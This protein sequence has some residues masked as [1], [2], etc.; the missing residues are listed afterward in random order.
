MERS[1]GADQRSKRALQ[2]EIGFTLMRQVR[3]ICKLCG[4]DDWLKSSHII[5]DFV[6]RWMTQTGTGYLRVSG[7][8]NIRRQGGIR[9]N[10]LC[11]EC[12]QR[13]SK[14]EDWFK[15]KVFTPYIDIGKLD[16]KYD[17]TLA[18]FII[19]LLWRL[20]FETEREHFAPH[21]H[22]FEHFEREWREYLLGR[23]ALLSTGRLYMYAT[24]I[25]ASSAAELPPG[26]NL[27]FTRAIDGS[28]LTN[29]LICVM[30]AKLPRFIFLAE[31]LYPA[32][33]PE[34]ITNSVV[35]PNGGTF[36]TGDVVMLAQLGHLLIDRVRL[37]TDMYSKL[38][39]RQRQRIN[40][41]TF[42]K[43]ERDRIA[44]SDYSRARMADDVPQVIHIPKARKIGRNELCPCGS[45]KKFK[46]CHGRE[47]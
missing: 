18:Y 8:P 22:L 25:V 10:L 40:D 19:S 23:S 24:D 43:D 1:Q 33:G 17:C 20:L 39:Q 11:E 31:L 46:K 3:G 5:P 38:S 47:A 15:R 13:F 7:N 32:N 30:Y 2:E 41:R 14:A 44:K 28:P 29:D 36:R 4:S 34:F 35:H 42:T 9:Q 21:E 6:T 45:A 27:Y 37:L 26:W 16:L 12:E